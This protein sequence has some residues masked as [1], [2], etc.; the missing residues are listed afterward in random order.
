MKPLFVIAAAVVIPF[1]AAAAFRG[2]GRE[3]TSPP[4]FVGVWRGE[5]RD[6]V[7]GR[8]R[9]TLIV[10]QGKV[11]FSGTWVAEFSGGGPGNGGSL[12]G[13]LTGDVIS[14]LLLSSEP[15]NCPFEATGKLSGNRA[16]GSYSA[17]DCPAEIEGTFALIRQ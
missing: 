17:R 2:D 9:L 6:S 14:A 13:R 15:G 7:A 11:G 12:A 16:V 5:I 3:N 4:S 10:A 8:G 1:A